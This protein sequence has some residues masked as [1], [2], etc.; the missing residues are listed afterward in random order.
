MKKY[1]DEFEKRV[2]PAFVP[3]EMTIGAAARG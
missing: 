3:V 1:Q 2:K